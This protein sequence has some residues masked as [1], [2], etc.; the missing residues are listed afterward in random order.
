VAK[1]DGKNR[2]SV[3]EIDSPSMVPDIDMD[4][5]IDRA[6]SSAA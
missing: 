2:Y 1:N 5:M 4:A 6:R 3:Y